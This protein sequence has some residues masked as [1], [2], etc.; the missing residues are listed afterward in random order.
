[1]NKIIEFIMAT[2]LFGLLLLAVG[3]IETNPLASLSCVA[4]FGL[5]CFIFKD[6]WITEEDEEEIEF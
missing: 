2:C 5:G 3:F 1:M 6:A 4:A